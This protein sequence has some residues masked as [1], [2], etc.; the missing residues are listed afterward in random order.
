MDIRTD[1]VGLLV[2]QLTESAGF[3][4]DR[5]NGLTDAEYLW[6]PLEG[7]WS[8]RPR[9][10]IATT[11][12]YGPGDWL[13]D[14]ER[15]DPFAPGP[16]TTIAWRLNHLLSGIAGRW[17]W[18]FGSRTLDP[19]DVVD[20]SPDAVE[21]LDSLWSKVD[22]WVAGIEGLTDEQ[23]DQPGFGQYPWGLDP[24]LPFIGIV[25]WVNREFIHHMAEA[26]LLRDLWS[27]SPTVLR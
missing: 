12:A 25:R 14:S 8:I 13:L 23:L 17:E 18:T 7:M 9:D 11:G 2:E 10:Q 1:R 4:R 6:E 3:S 20:F 26:A 15:I 24:E 21:T 19:A 27:T 22:D 16:P 5:M